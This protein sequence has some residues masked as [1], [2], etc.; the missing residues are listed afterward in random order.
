[1]RGG[2]IAEG[3]G[4]RRWAVGVGALPQSGRYRITYRVDAID[5]RSS[6]NI[7]LGV[8]SLS[9]NIVSQSHTASPSGWYGWWSYSNGSETALAADGAQVQGG[10]LQKTKAGSVV[11][12]VVDQDAST[13]T[14]TCDGAHIGVIRNVTHKDLTPAA[15]VFWQGSALALLSVVPEAK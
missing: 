10:I 12:L 1:M 15:T 4:N 14:I 6:W 3:T 9:A 13:I 7:Y 11:A 8:G 5:A 2:V